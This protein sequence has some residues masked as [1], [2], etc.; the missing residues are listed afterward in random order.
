MGQISLN[1]PQVGL[2]DTTEDVKVANNFT[3][4]QNAINGNIDST[5][6]SATAAQSAGVNQSGQTVKGAAVIGT[7]QNTSSSTFATLATPDQVT[8][9]VLP[10]GG[11]IFVYYRA[12]WSNTTSQGGQAAIFLNSTQLQIDSGGA[13]PVAQQAVSNTTS[14]TQCG[15]VAWPA[16]LFSNTSASN[17]TVSDP[18]TGLLLGSG[19]AGG[20]SMITAAAGTYT[21]SIQFKASAGTTTVAGRRLYVQAVSFV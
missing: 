1:I 19:N 9:I 13:A 3:T 14:S 16:G 11:L 21:V 8:G 2:P 17:V 10:A 12:L 20:G 18:T 7:S 15:L 4:L 5:N 6:L